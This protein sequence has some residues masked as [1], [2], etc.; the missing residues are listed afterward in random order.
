LVTQPKR[1]IALG[2]FVL[3]WGAA[4]P[5]GCSSG[6]DAGETK[7]TLQI[8]GSGSIDCSPGGNYAQSDMPAT[9]PFTEPTL[10]QLTATPAEGWSFAGWSGDTT[11]TSNPAV[12][13]VTGSMDVLA[14]FEED[15][16]PP[17]T[18][19][20]SDINVDTSIP[21]GTYLV[22]SDVYV[23]GG[24]TLT[25]QPG[26]HIQFG[27]SARLIIEDDGVASFVGTAT[28]P[29]VLTGQDA[30][31]GFWQGVFFSDSNSTSNVL[32]YVTV[33]YAGNEDDTSSG[34]L[35]IEQGTRLALRHC[36]LRHSAGVGLAV[37]N[38]GY[39]ARL[40]LENNVLTD[41]AMG[42]ATVLIQQVEALNA[43]NTFSGN[44]RERVL[45]GAGTDQTLT[46]DTTMP[47]LDVDYQ[48]T[49]SIY[50]E[51]HLTIAP[52]VRMLFEDDLLLDVT[53]AGILTAV[54]TA[55]EPIVFSAVDPTP[56]YWMGINFGDSNSV[57]NIM[58]YFVVEY[59]GQNTP[60]SHGAI[61]V[62]NGSRV[63]IDHGTVRGG[64]G[65]GIWIRGANYNADIATANSFADNAA[66]DFHLEE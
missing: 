19:I 12:V 7:L 28:A 60:W 39:E 66:G 22:E 63:Q 21:A 54:G 64:E 9:V 26:V 14:L 65:W 40:T 62:W 59:A 18:T 15:G 42:A 57:S 29:I 30:T 31:P 4:I 53:D 2:L 34:D 20:T 8:S 32:E 61:V 38:N 5:A 44:T 41:N 51:A 33:E 55:A 17:T 58:Q 24:A 48:V 37:R 46:R 25:L 35:V 6:D 16:A 45:L 27:R 1:R 49:G 11:S 36:T 43:T 13:M 52:G 56:G 10:V 47:A 3:G 23:Y 50:L